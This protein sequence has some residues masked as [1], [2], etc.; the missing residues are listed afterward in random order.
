[1]RCVL[2]G[3][4]YIGADIGA[5]GITGGA[6]GEVRAPPTTGLTEVMATIGTI[7]ITQV[8]MHHMATTGRIVIIGHTGTIGRMGIIPRASPSGWTFRVRDAGLNARV[9][10]LEEKQAH[11]VCCAM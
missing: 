3:G 11:F 7:L 1:M 6:G 10:F 5:I 4:R 9:Y 8:T 2:T